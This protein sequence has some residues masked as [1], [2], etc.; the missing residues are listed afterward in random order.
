MMQKSKI[1]IVD[2]EAIFV[3]SLERA[4]KMAGY[5]VCESA[6]SGEE[7][8]EKVKKEN[9]DLVI[10]DLCLSC[11]ASGVEIA[12]RI[13]SISNI[14]IVFISGFQKEEIESEVKEIEEFVYLTKP[15]DPEELIKAIE[16]LNNNTLSHRPSK[17]SSV[18]MNRA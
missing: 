9:P 5:N 3:M 4:L 14:P 16:I 11:D 6:L 15:F 12:K 10:L 8:L 17:E 18:P 1:L 7:A 2:D 13:R